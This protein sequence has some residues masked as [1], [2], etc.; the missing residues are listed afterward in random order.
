MNDM[1]DTKDINN[2]KTNHQPVVLIILDGFGCRQSEKDNAIA[3][4][5]TPTWD[6]L[7]QENPHAELTAA[8]LSVGLPEGQMG[9]SEVGHL[10]M[11]AGRVIFQDLTRINLA[12]QDGSFFQNSIFLEAMHKAKTSHK[13]VHILGLISNGGVHSHEDHIIAL[14]QLAKQHGLHNIVVHAFL[15]GRDTPPQSALTSLL[16]LE[17]C[18]HELQNAHIATLC[19]RYY[20]MDR[21]KRYERTEAAYRMLTEGLAP[22]HAKNVEEGLNLAYQRKETD[23]F[24]QPTLIGQQTTIQDGDIV[25]F[26]NF[27]A[28]RARQLSRALTDPNFSGFQ[29]RIFPKLAEFVTLT[30]YEKGLTNKIAFSSLEIKNL[31]GEYLEKQNLKQLRIAETEKYAHVTYFFDGGHDAAYQGEDCILIPSPKVGTYD[32][33]P[34][35]SANQIT[36]ELVKVILSQRYDVIICNFAN[37]DMLGHT[38]D[39]SAT[40]KAIETLDHCLMHITEALKE[41]QG[42]ALITADHGNAEYMFDESTGQ[43]HTAHTLSLVPFIYLGRPATITHHQGSLADIA[44]TLLTALG[45]PIPEEMTG[46]SL[47]KFK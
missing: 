46:S 8:G 27:R 35:M 5:N 29:R 43:P 17:R 4:A 36:D 12:I 7:W 28:D 24:V 21:D 37:A 16:K 34:E 9:N 20:A 42:E 26:M 39:F 41:V 47:I 14:L 10:T 2:I 6:K 44:P 38:G 18:C 32:H 22:Y 19:G 30:F 3:A 1:N 45:L 33:C 40:V 13:T 11:G 23:E 25:F 15:D 31:L